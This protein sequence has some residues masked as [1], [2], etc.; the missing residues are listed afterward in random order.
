MMVDK[1]QL[2]TIIQCDQCKRRLKP[3]GAKLPNV[4]QKALPAPSGRRPS[5]ASDE[6]CSALST[7]HGGPPEE[8]LRTLEALSAGEAVPKPSQRDEECEEEERSYAIEQDSETSL[9]EGETFVLVVCECGKTLQKKFRSDQADKRLKCPDCG[10]VH[11]NFVDTNDA[12]F[13]VQQ[14]SSRPRARK[15]RRI[16]EDAEPL[17]TGRRVGGGTNAGAGCVG[18]VLGTFLVLLGIMLSSANSQSRIYYGLIWV[19]I[20]SILQGSWAARQGQTFWGISTLAWF[21][22]SLLS[23]GLTFAIL[24]AIWPHFTQMTPQRGW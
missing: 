2:G 18:L 4:S 12:A 1:K 20:H 22:I 5:Q 14:P 3:S 17:F 24:S 15:R 23:L 7:S 13:D 11:K 21:F 19:G 6:E 16:R 10:R 9:A 8:M